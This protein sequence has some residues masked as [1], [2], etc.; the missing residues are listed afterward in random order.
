MGQKEKTI[1]EGTYWSN[2]SWST[3]K[4]RRGQQT[5]DKKTIWMSGSQEKWQ[6]IVLN[7]KCDGEED[8]TPERKNN[9]VKKVGWLSPRIDLVF[10]QI[11]C[12]FT[13]LPM[14]V[15]GLHINC[16]VEQLER[17]MFKEN[18]TKSPPYCIFRIVCVVLSN[19][20]FISCLS[21][22]RLIPHQLYLLA[23][24]LRHNKRL[25]LSSC[26]SSVVWPQ[27]A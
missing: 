2:G 27:T 6:D 13:K 23:F 3:S 18:Y 22:K 15:I 9:I 4:D 17:N 10:E 1:L 25:K 20:Y 12:W 26:H 19:L 11:C 14:C 7:W 21:A 8:L 5:Q 24:L 16:L